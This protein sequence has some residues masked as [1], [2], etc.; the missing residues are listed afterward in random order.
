MSELNRNLPF[1][2]V[3]YALTVSPE[4]FTALG[5]DHNDIVRLF[6]WQDRTLGVITVSELRRFRQLE[7]LVSRN[8]QD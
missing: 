6:A 1:P 7:Q 4:E 2:P 3:D 5:F 8:A